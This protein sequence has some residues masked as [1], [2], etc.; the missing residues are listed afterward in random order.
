M[1]SIIVDIGEL[2]FLMQGLEELFAHSPKGVLGSER[3]EDMAALHE[4]L[5]LTYRAAIDETAGKV[6]SLEEGDQDGRE[7]TG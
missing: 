3:R 2:M 6:D 5:Q 7:T 4:R 1:P